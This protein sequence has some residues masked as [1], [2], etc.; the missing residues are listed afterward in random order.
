LALL[1][2]DFD[3]RTFVFAGC[4]YVDAG[5][6]TFLDTSIDFTMGVIRNPNS[7]RTSGDI[8]VIVAK[9]ENFEQQIMATTT[10]T[11]AGTKLAVAAVN[12]VDLTVDP[13]S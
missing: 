2:K 1:T 7:T 11:L 5:E 6:R 10:L 12:D 3:T 13:S 8:Q 4:L 9:D